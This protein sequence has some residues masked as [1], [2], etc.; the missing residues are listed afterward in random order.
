[1]ELSHHRA[2]DDGRSTWVDVLRRPVDSIDDS[3]LP[4]AQRS[5]LEAVHRLAAELHERLA[6][7]H[8]QAAAYIDRHGTPAAARTHRTIAEEE[9][10]AAAE[11]RRRHTPTVSNPSSP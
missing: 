11:Q 1:M 7:L 4:K 8:D 10:H 9:R 2:H 6:V 5:R 3:A